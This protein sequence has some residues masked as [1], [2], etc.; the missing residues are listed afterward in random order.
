MLRAPLPFQLQD[1]K[2]LHQELDKAGLSN[3]RVE[4]ITE[5]LEFHSGQQL[6]DWLTNSNPIVG[7]VLAD[8]SLTDEQIAV[9]QRALDEMVQKRAGESAT[10]TL[11]NPINIGVGTK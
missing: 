1:P 6:W 10:A 11:T 3:I 5:T 8:L 9:V 4:T 7:M 2:K